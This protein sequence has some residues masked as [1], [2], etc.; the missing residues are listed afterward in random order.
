MATI[1]M[2]QM[3][4]AGVHF[5]HQTRFWNPKMSPYIFGERNKIH[6]INLEKSLPLYLQAQEFVRKL[7]SDGGSVLFVGTK[8]SAREAIHRE[9]DRCGMPY[10]SYRWLGGM[11]TNY[12]TVRQSIK[13]LAELESM[14]E[15]GTFERLAKK[16]VLGLKREMDKLER[17]LGGIKQM[18]GL[19]DALFIIDIE[20]ERIALAEANKL[21]IPV[22]AIVD[23]NCSP[24]GVDYVIPGNDD[25]MRAIQLYAAGI[26]DAV[27]EGKASVPEVPV[28]EDEFVEVDDAGQA[29][30]RTARKTPG[31]R[32]R[33]RRKAPAPA[34]A[35]A[36]GAQAAELAEVQE[37]AAADADAGAAAESEAAP[38]APAAEPAT[39]RAEQEQP[40]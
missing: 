19:P 3:L 7:A 27:L 31:G 35:R 37:Q 20:H 36:E 11:L 2:R 12:K 10:V 6:I 23:T 9:A 25:A 34:G 15:D 13:R 26:A 4:E 21:G 28:G 18:G 16:E 30:R 14:S 1:S 33:A 22:V 39:E 5:G 24:E 17:S 29:R 32:S 38:D 40:S 8:R